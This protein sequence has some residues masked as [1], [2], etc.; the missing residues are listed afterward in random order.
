MAGH[1]SH[2][3]TSPQTRFGFEPY[4]RPRPRDSPAK[5]SGK[6]R[7][8][9]SFDKRL[10]HF[11]PNTSIDAT[12]RHASGGGQTASREQ[13]TAVRSFHRPQLAISSDKV[14]AEARL[15]P[16][17]YLGRWT[18]DP[19]TRLPFRLRVNARFDVHL[20]IRYLDERH[21]HAIGRRKVW[22]T[23]IYTDDSDLAALV[24][25]THGG[26]MPSTGGDLRCSVRVLPRLFS[27][28]GST[29]NDLRSRGWS[30][31]HDGLSLYLEHVD[32]TSWQEQVRGL[33][34]AKRKLVE[35]TGLKRTAVPD[36]FLRCDW[37]SKKYRRH[38]GEGSD[39]DVDDAQ[40]EAAQVAQAG[41]APSAK[42]VGAESPKPGDAAADT[43]DEGDDEHGDSA[44]E[45][46]P[47]GDVTI[48]MDDQG[49][50]AA[51]DSYIDR[52]VEV[53]SG[54]PAGVESKE[55]NLLESAPEQQTEGTNAQPVA[56]EV[57][58]ENFV[59]QPAEVHQVDAAAVGLDT[60]L[61]SVR[62]DESAAQTSGTAAEVQLAAAENE[63]LGAKQG[64]ASPKQD[65]K[66]GEESSLE[67][68][69]QKDEA[70]AVKPL[71]PSGPPEM[72]AESV[73]Q[74]DREAAA[75]LGP[76][77]VDVT[78]ESKP[79]D[80]KIEETAKAIEAD[81]TAK[82]LESVSGD[83]QAVKA[84]EVEDTLS[85]EQATGSALIGTGSDPNIAERQEP[86]ADA[87]PVAAEAQPKDS[88]SEVTVDKAT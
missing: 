13:A 78:L 25:H 12:N 62:A 61:Q 51:D 11:S 21:N 30:T 68:D 43:E 19:T 46:V 60:D 75:A 47:D 42:A 8:K 4:D 85:A 36:P 64:V 2:S 63:A 9:S 10:H 5:E 16:E 67:R 17:A 72:T 87:P 56:S 82:P 1:H 31:P 57:L 32:G 81:T 15:H 52:S 34:F 55:G 41:G 54:V 83:A 65:E 38:Q 74:L 7:R 27:Y 69:V 73:A 23:D 20:P 49:T 6:S 84:Q 58:A 79:I 80:V 66:P 3:T 29:R 39:L 76:A 70:S 35:S 71:S 24:L 53:E 77:A 14:F 59:D 22:G 26:G 18:Y 50:E 45:V 40:G 33:G 86:D 37:R 48:E 28:K 88:R 44:M